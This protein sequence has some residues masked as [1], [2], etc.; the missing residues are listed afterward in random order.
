MKFGILINSQT[1][2]FVYKSLFD[3]LVDELS[4]LNDFRYHFVHPLIH[5]VI[6]IVVNFFSRTNDSFIVN[7]L[8][9]VSIGQ[10]VR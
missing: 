3:G 8:N 4:H 9:L 7:R 10:S 6:M 5:D 1:Y 2:S